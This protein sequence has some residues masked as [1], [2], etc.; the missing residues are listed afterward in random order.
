M[1]G[2]KNTFEKRRR[3]V[4]RKKKREEKLQRKIDKKFQP[5]ATFEE[6]I[7][8]GKQQNAENNLSGNENT[9]NNHE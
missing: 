3:E 8:S 2:S 6:M 4:D 9:N 1:A 5:T 7:E